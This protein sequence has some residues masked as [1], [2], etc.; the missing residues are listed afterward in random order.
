MSIQTRVLARLP[1]LPRLKPTKAASS[2]VEL[3]L[4]DDTTPGSSGR[5]PKSPRSVESGDV[6]ALRE[7]LPSYAAEAKVDMGFKHLSWILGG[8]GG[9]Y[10]NA[11]LHAYGPAYGAG[12]AVM[13]FF[14]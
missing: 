4:G 7:A 14:P 12:C 6:A 5:T 1:E 8:L 3:A 2:G 9:G 10:S 13:E 11:K